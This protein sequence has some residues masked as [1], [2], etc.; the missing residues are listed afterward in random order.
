MHRFF[1]ALR[2]DAGVVAVIATTLLLD[3][4]AA[5]WAFLAK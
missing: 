5:V 2:E 4:V 3:V 1:E